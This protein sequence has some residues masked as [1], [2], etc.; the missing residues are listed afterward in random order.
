MSRLFKIVFF[1]LGCELIGILSSVF[2]ISSIPTW[3]QSLNKPFFNPP[4]WVF[5]PAWTTLYL[6]MGIS[7][8]L[9]LEKA[10]KNKKKYLSVLFVL[11]LFLNFLWTF[12]FFGLHSPILAFIEIILLWIS[13]LIL[14]IEFKKYS[15]EASILLV[16]YIFWV[17]FASLLNLFIVILN[18]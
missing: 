1:I 6:L 9:V 17:T 2:T 5:G 15:K 8:F 4:N 14:I 13:I 7:I 18:K 11:Q 12:I 10:P 16:P 3:Y